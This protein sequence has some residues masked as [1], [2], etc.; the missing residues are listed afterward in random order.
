MKTLYFDLIGG[1]SG[2]MTVAA[3]VD[4]GLPQAVLR[5][6]LAGLK[7]KG[8]DVRLRTVERG[9]VRARACDVTVKTPRNYAYAEIVRLIRGARLPQGCR[10]R[11]L[12][13]YAVLRDAEAKAHGHAGTR[14]DQLGDADSLFDVAAVSAGLD[15]LDCDEVLY[16]PLPL[17]QRFGPAT[18][19]MLEGKDVFFLPYLHENV[20]PTGMALLAA[21]G[22]QVRPP[23]SATY[24]FGRCGYG[25]G[26]LDPAGLSN[27]LRIAAL[28]GR[29]TWER[30]RVWVIE[31][32]IDDMNP[33]FFEDAYERLFD[34]GALDVSVTN[35]MMKKSR[36]G[37]LLTVLSRPADFDAIT[38][39]ILRRTTTT[40]LRYNEAGRLK[41]PRR[42]RTVTWL[43]QRVRCKIC[44]LPGAGTKIV[45]E[46]DDCRA[47]AAATGRT[48]QEVYER[49]QQQTE[50]VS[51]RPCSP[52][53]RE[54][55]EPGRF[56]GRRVG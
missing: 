1:I 19:V 43:G 55:D 37:F 18:G 45:P 47:A 48:L 21:L 26:S 25:A 27:V 33:Q 35:V 51:V 13:V 41:W 42:E 36:P 40:G 16:G 39:I 10:Q 44:T 49:V 34:A 15:Y 52:G 22:R 29:P 28:E 3:L 23:A 17:C 4:L 38:R 30:D 2:D 54:A 14:F 5:R 56:K 6:T 53:R 9:H 12:R 46:Y 50:D 31:A 20:T 7:M 11:A 24:V 32:N 8:V